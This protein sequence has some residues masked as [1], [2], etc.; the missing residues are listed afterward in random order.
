MS[1]CVDIYQVPGMWHVTR[2]SSVRD[3]KPRNTPE[4]LYLWY[5]NTSTR[6]KQQ[7]LADPVRVEGSVL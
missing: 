1:R 2:K 3:A 4:V 7:F 6:I 5:Y